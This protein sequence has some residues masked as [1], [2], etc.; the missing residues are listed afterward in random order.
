MNLKQVQ[1]GHELKQEQFGHELKQ[2]QFQIM[3]NT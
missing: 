1:F 2:E 3:T